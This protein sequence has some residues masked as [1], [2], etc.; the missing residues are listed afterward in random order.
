VVRYHDRVARVYDLIYDDDPYWRFYREVTWRQM[1]PHL[2]R[3]ADSRVLDAGG[4]TGIWA[5]RLA[6]AGLRVT[7][8]DISERM[9]DVAR[10]K[11]ARAGLSDRIECVHADI[12]GLDGL[13]SAGFDFALAEGD[14]I[15]FCR[16]ARAAARAL[17]RV[18][19]PGACLLASVDGTWAALDHVVAEGGIDG[20]EAFI[21]H[22]R[23]EFLAKDPDERFP[24][25]TFTPPEFR[26]LLT[27][28]GFEI[29][30]L[31]GRTVLPVRA[32]RDRLADRDFFDRLLA[33]EIRLHAE[34]ALLGRAGHLAAVARRP[35]S[36]ADGK[37]D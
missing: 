19:R 25:R 6:K 26:G 1:K 3:D 8:A 17:F 21:R 37:S 33:L 7:I 4:G 34:E 14:P 27:G 23:T 36:A 5:L 30:S 24:T 20:L 22:G 32:L 2:P 16:D 13:P 9:L 28:A 10:D 35:A 18:L 29:L 11:A 12:A 15:S 31:T